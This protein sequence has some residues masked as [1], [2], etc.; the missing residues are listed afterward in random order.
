MSVDHQVLEPDAVL[1]DAGRTARKQSLKKQ[2]LPNLLANGGIFVLNILLGMWYT[3]YLI[4]HLGVAAYGLVPLANSL[5]S[6]LSLVSLSLNG[7]AGRF[8]TLDLAKQEY[9]SANRTFNTVLF[10]NVGLVALTLP[11][12]IGLALV[13]PHW[14]DI[15]VGLEV[16][17]QWLFAATLFSYLLTLLQSSFSVSSWARNRF[18]LRNAVIALHHLA[19]VGLVVAA[20]SLVQPALWHVGLGIFGATLLGF[21]G[22]VWLWRKLTPQLHV[23]LTS[24]DRSRVRELFSMGGWLVVNQIGTLLFLKIDLIVANILLGAEIAGEYGSLILFSTMLR[25]LAQTA[26]TVLTPTVLAKYAHGDMKAVNRISQQAVKFSGLALALP[27]GL[28]CGLAQPLLALWLGPEFQ[29]LAG[30]LVMLTAHLVINLAVQPL[31]GLNMAFNKVSLPGIVTLVMGVMNV[32]LA[33]ALARLGWGAVGIAA[34]GALVLTLKNALFTPIYAA[35]IQKLPWWTFM[36]TMFLIILAAF[37]VGGMAYAATQLIQVRSWF[38]LIAVG[39]GLS[40]LYTAAVYFGLLRKEDRDL[41][42]TLLPANAWV[43]SSRL[44]NRD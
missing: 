18:D 15:P 17:T 23:Q 5:T 7:A 37:F 14:F 4:H 1:P 12:V 34:A 35:Y 38:M 31:F 21:A 44:L 42:F 32:G 43:Q 9:G 11:L 36:K 13:A 28:I 29:R 27:I 10:G 3:P 22:D 33:V 6:Y 39:G 8:L 30:L 41:L 24:F 2:F 40:L 19:R 26:S 20:F 25:Q 16:Y